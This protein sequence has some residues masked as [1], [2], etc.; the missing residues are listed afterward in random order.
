M[1]HFQKDFALR[2]LCRPSP[3][4]KTTPLPVCYNYSDE[5]VVW[6]FWLFSGYTGFVPFHRGVN[7]VR[8]AESTK[9]GLRR[10]NGCIREGR[11]VIDLPPGPATMECFNECEHPNKPIYLVNQGFMNSYSGNLPGQFSVSRSICL[12]VPG[13]VSVSASRLG[14]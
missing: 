7:G 14:L 6:G 4:F 8:F 3:F 11:G 1:E 13:S 5:S 12:S 10:F 2:H 9:E